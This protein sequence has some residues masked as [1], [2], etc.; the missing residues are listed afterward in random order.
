[1]RKALSWGLL[2]L[3][4]V[5]RTFAQEPNEATRVAAKADPTRGA[6]LRL[7]DVLRTALSQGPLV[8]AAQARVRAAAAAAR[9]A[10]AFPNPVLTW[11]VENGPFPGASSPASAARET[12]VFATLPL[13]FFFQRGPQMRRAEQDLRTAEAELASAR[14]LVA[15]DAARAFGHV[16]TAQAALAAASDLSRGLADLAAFNQARVAE[17][18]TPEG[19]LIRVGVERDR[20]ILEEAL[21]EAELA[22]AWAE[23][24][25]FLPGLS[26][27]P[28]PRLTLGDPAA[29]PLPPLAEL[30]EKSRASQPE[31][32]AARARLASTRAQAT[33]ERRQLVRQVGAVFGT[34]RVA[35]EN[36]MIAGLNLSVP[37]FDRN[38]AGAERADAEQDAAE[39]ELAWAE[40]RISAQVEA[41]HRSA[42]VMTARLAALEPDL[43]GR[44]EESRRVA[45]AAYREGAGSLLQ[46]LDASRAAAEARQT[47]GRALMAREQ[48]VLDLRA[49][50][51]GDPLDGMDTDREGNER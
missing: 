24:R 48:G 20:T 44:A 13:E 33:F 47:L 9:S 21:A 45:M 17:G 49:A 50:R 7:G 2:A 39:Q 10:Q 6:E 36:T 42:E 8:E 4:S 25:P 27:F 12:S 29:S 37:L 14:W 41:A 19:E 23:L 11:Q 43:L 3:L 46:V 34:K 5:V 16:L 15:R 31:I 28:P 22:S 30:L 51:G 18:V 40:R 32:L 38:R 26:L 1:M 35:G